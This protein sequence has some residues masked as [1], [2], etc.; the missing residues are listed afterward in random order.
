MH[1]FR[2]QFQPLQSHPRPLTSDVSGTLRDSCRLHPCR[3]GF[4]QQKLSFPQPHAAVLAQRSKTSCCVSP[5][6]CEQIRDSVACPTTG[7]NAILAG[8]SRRLD[9]QET[10]AQEAQVKRS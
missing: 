1:F 9:G 4:L 2:S 8:V 6:C 7:D 5:T 3:E 10:K